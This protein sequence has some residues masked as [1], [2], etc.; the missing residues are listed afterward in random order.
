MK[1]LLVF[2][3]YMLI[4]CSDPPTDGIVKAASENCTSLHKQVSIE[5][6]SGGGYHIECKDIDQK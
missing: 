1:P 2:I 3:G 5:Y 4:S 6:N